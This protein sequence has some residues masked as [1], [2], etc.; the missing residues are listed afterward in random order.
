MALSLLLVRVFTSDNSSVWHIGLYNSTW[1]PLHI[2]PHCTSLLFIAGFKQFEVK[3][4]K[5]EQET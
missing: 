2:I 3:I 5:G 4:F 1:Y